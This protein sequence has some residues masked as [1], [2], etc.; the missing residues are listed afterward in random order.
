MPYLKARNSFQARK[1]NTVV[2][3]L[4]VGYE[5][6]IRKAVQGF[7]SFVFSAPLPAWRKNLFSAS[8]IFYGG[9]YQPSCTGIF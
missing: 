7:F 4:I 3:N 8:G 5:L 9:R 6:N 2:P 1:L